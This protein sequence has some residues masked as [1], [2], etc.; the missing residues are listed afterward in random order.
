MSSLRSKLVL[1]IILLSLMSIA[2][3]A[4][5]SRWNAST[6]FQ[7]FVFDRNQENVISGLGTYYRET[8]SWEGVRE[9]FPRVP[10]PFGEGPSPIGEIVL[11]DLAGRVVIGGRGYHMGDQY[12][13]SN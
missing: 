3:I 4:A 11:L 12:S 7:R 1:T 6:E 2:L 8:G 13:P 9:F 10:M 5:F